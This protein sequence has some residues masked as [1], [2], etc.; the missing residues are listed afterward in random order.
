MQIKSVSG[1]TCYVKDLKKTIE[2][3]E[4][5][6]FDFKQKEATHAKGYINW[7]WIDFVAVPTETK[8][9][10][11]KEANSV[12]KG[13]GIYVNLSVDNVDDFYK[14]V[15]EKGMKPSSEP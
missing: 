15:V 6:G 12:N 10:F 2:F 5:L 13:A 11:L 9:E 1:I 4:A 8:E 14:G 7:F 3:Y